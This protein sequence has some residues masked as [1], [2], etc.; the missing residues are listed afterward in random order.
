L[1]KGKTKKKDKPV[2]DK[3][4]GVCICGHKGPFSLKIQNHVLYRICKCG[5][6]KNM[7]AG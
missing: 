1:G 6:V 7:D 2:S 3:R 5:D 4:A